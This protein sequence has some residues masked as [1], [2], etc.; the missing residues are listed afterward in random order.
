MAGMDTRAQE[1]L[2]HLDELEK[3]T[4][5]EPY[6]SHFFEWLRSSE[7]LAYSDSRSNVI[8]PSVKRLLLEWADPI[9]LR[10]EIDGLREIVK[11]CDA[12]LTYGDVEGMSGAR[13][14]ANLTLDA[15]GQ[16]LPGMDPAET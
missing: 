10:G 12:A 14:L 16:V 9:A 1:L 6:D 3:L 4:E 15:L 2:A 11:A 7:T 5:L 8:H 13:V